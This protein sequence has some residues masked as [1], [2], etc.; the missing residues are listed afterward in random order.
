METLV[1]VRS[2]KGRTLMIIYP[3]T[4]EKCGFYKRGGKNPEFG[5]IKDMLP[6]FVNWVNNRP[7]VVGTSTFEDAEANVRRVLC[8]EAFRGENDDFGIIL[9]NEIPQHEDGVPSIPIKSRVGNVKAST[10]EMPEESIPGWPTY[11]WIVPNKSLI[12]SLVP[13]NMKG[14]RSSGIT[15]AKKYLEHYMKLHSQYVVYEQKKEEVNSVEKEISGWRAGDNT[16]N[17]QLYCKFHTK[18]L[19]LPGFINYIRQK[20]NEI[21]KLT[22]KSK[23]DLEM[24]QD[25]TLLDAALKFIGLSNR[26]ENNLKDQIKYRTQ[27]DWTPS[28]EDLEEVIRQWEAKVNDEKNG[29]ELGVTFKGNSTIYWFDRA[30]GKQE[31]EITPELQN[32]VLWTNDQLKQV[33]S[34]SKNRIYDTVRRAGK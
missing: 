4:I 28:K 29:Y 3:Y 26:E 13:D 17:P 27:M 25:K 18:E 21:R 23:L 2:N 31:L 24:P 20:C 6:L 30:R 16:P 5:A 22:V 15:Q 1:L 11:L 19:R 12:V 32:A 10:T 33:W 8:L 14:F 34:L 9:W 7:N